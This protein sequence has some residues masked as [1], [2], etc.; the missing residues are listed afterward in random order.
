M[1]VSSAQHIPIHSEMNDFGPF[2]D[3]NTTSF[4]DQFGTTISTDLLHER[5][6][7]PQLRILPLGA[8]I[9]WGEGSSKGNG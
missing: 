7:K 2:M 3:L 8:S 9:V 5:A 6:D 4:D 1:A